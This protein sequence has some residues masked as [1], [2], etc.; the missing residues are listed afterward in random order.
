MYKRKAEYNDLCKSFLFNLDLF[1]SFKINSFQTSHIGPTLW[2]N[3]GPKSRW[4]CFCCSLCHFSWYQFDFISFIFVLTLFPGDVEVWFYSSIWY[5]C[6]IR[7]FFYFFSFFWISFHSFSQVTLDL[8]ELERTRTFKIGQW[9]TRASFLLVQITM[10]PLLSAIMWPSVSLHFLFNSL[11]LFL[12]CHDRSRVFIARLY[13]WG[14]V[15]R[16]HGI[17]SLRWFVYGGEQYVGCTHSRSPTHSHSIWTGKSECE[18]K[19]QTNIFLNVSFL[20]LSCG[21]AILLVTFAIWLM[22]RRN[23]FELRQ[24]TIMMFLRNIRFLSFSFSFFIVYSNFF[25]LGWVLSSSSCSH[26][27]SSWRSWDRME[28][29]PLW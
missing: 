14:W 11:L 12:I 3:Y 29:T 1:H 13:N 6:V 5:N 2:R 10:A 16:R 24:K 9:L 4:K 15:P 8:F 21:L 27:S 20:S 17:D 28:T 26:P 23:G 18:K 22:A 7:G 25:L 19:K